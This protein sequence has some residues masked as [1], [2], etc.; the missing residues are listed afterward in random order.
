MWKRREHVLGGQVQCPL[1]SRGN[2]RQT[3]T[4]PSAGKSRNKQTQIASE[5]LPSG[6]WKQ[7][8][9]RGFLDRKSLLRL[10][11]QLLSDIYVTAELWRVP[12]GKAKTVDSNIGE[13]ELWQEVSKEETGRLE[14]IWNRSKSEWR[15]SESVR[16]GGFEAIWGE[17]AGR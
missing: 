3:W 2:K 11:S 16:R 17:M 1:E 9:Q 14:R 13:K 7:N 12:T 8:Y 5:N 4:P 15:W 10:F 6:R